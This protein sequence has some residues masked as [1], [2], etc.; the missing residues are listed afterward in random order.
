[1]RHMATRTKTKSSK[2][3][4]S[5]TLHIYTRVSTV[6]Q[7]D[8]GT[9]L[10]TQLQ[11]GIKRA[12]QLKFSYKHWDEG[13]K[14]SHHENIEDRPVLFE[15][16]Q[17]I[18]AG[19]I[20][21][22]W[23]YDQSR[24]SRNDQV[25]SLFRY[26]CNKQ[27]VTLY[28][29]DGQLDLSNPSDMFLK[30]IFDAVA[31]LENATRAE[32]T[33]LGKLTRVSDGFWHGGPPPFGYKLVDKR[34]TIEK[35]ESV[36]VKKIFELSLKG[37]G[38]L[39]IKKYLDSKGVLPRR[40]KGL[41]SLGSV[42]ALI[43]NTHYKGEYVYQDK[44]SK[45]TIRVKCPAIVDEVTWTAVQ[46]IK[47]RKIS[48]VSQQN[49]TT[50][51]YLLRDL[52]FCGHCGRPMAG[53]QNKAKNEALYYCP[54]KQRTWV[55]EGGTKTPWKRGENCGL[56]RSLNIPESDRLVFDRVTQIHKD[57]S[58]L[59]EE[60]KW[61]IL[62]ENNAPLARNYEDI[63]VLERTLKKQQKE[64]DGAKQA[65][66]DL[67]LSH[68]S[69]EIKGDIF[70]RALDNSKQRIEKLEV[71]IANTKIEIRGN[72]ENKQWVD[73]VRV[74]GQQIDGFKDL[75]DED[76]RD[77]LTGLIEKISVKYLKP[78]NQ[79][80]LTIQFNLPIVGDSIKWN[81]P[82]NRKK[83]YKVVRGKKLSVVQVKQ[84]DPRWGKATPERNDSVTVE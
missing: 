74:Y 19:D 13:G 14:S 22:L 15:L 2:G 8:K 70:K 53:R 25:A 61:K 21:H 6:A 56:E 3:M 12:R 32:R 11:L 71:L 23:I 82:E 38:T 35:K 18:K 65:Q 84:K 24:L 37:Y 17:S 33:R 16:F 28:T 43:H 77:Y 34:L 29:K 80:E 39:D 60:V 36:W 5:A 42:L 69:G 62:K 76:R 75:P 44:K 1:M 48:R 52:M 68:H 81:D 45:K 31:S 4:P 9:S 51:F 78:S 72:V 54:N 46:K 58:V 49:R 66:A 59:K 55:T 40:S 79:H 27:G 67:V 41:W 63:Q 30:Q 47:T 7:A 26:E 57:S 20:K 10:D 83:G 50:H 64:L 73:W